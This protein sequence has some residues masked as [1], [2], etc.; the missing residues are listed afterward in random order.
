LRALKE[1]NHIQIL[2]NPIRVT[3][4]K[5][6]GEIP[7]EASMFLKNIDK[8][9]NVRDLTKILTEKY[10]PVFTS[11]ISYDENGNNRNYGYVQF[12]KTESSDKLLKEGSTIEI[13]GTKI[14]VTRYLPKGGR[15]GM[16]NFRF[17]NNYFHNFL[18]FSNY[19]LK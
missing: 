17:L 13:N 9:I 3:L 12:E 6:Y 8:S 11:K 10:G 19:F 1:A 5:K 4:K 2:N 15:Q 18:K 14:N 7:K 16:L